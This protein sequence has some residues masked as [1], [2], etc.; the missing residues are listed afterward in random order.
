MPDLAAKLM[1]NEGDKLTAMALDAGGDEGTHVLGEAEWGVWLRY[2]LMKEIGNPPI[3]NMTD[4][5]DAL[6]AMKEK[7]RLPGGQSA[8]VLTGFLKEDW[9]FE[10]GLMMPWTSGQGIYNLDGVYYTPDYS[11]KAVTLG[12]PED[13]LVYYESARW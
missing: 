6:K 4:V 10:W 12:A 1:L 3:N 7:F 11:G 2:D 9:G 5:Y 8:L 13:T